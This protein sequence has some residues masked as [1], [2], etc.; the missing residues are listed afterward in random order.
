M[1]IEVDGLEDIQETLEELEEKTEKTLPLMGELK[2]HL[3]NVIGESFES[4]SSPD[5]IAW[6]PIKIK[7]VHDT[8]KGKSRYTKKGVQT[9][10]FQRFSAGRKILFDT[11]NMQKS[12]YHNTKKWDLTVGLNATSKGYAYPLVHQFGSKHVEA[13]P[14]MPV[15]SNGELYESTQRELEEIIDEWFELEGLEL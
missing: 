8:Y 4:Q 5:G 14:F 11:G 10:A 6:S 2:N 15:K 12:L 1:Q 3:Y 7:T 9:K 13:R